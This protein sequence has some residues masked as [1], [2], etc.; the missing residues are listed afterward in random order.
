MC[1]IG[2]VAI[3]VIPET[4]PNR[5][6]SESEKQNQRTANH[7][8]EQAMEELLNLGRMDNVDNKS[9]IINDYGFGSVGGNIKKDNGGEK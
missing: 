4:R 1:Q 2:F 6:D 8:F 5:A 7:K 3:K 9:L